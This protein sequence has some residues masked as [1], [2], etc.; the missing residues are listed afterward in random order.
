MGKGLGQAE[1]KAMARPRHDQPV[2]R[3]IHAEIRGLIMRGEFTV[4]SLL[5]SEAKLAAIYRINKCTLRQAL[6]LLRDDGMLRAI[7]SRGWEI[8]ASQPRKA[9]PRQAQ[10]VFMLGPATDSAALAFQ[11]AKRAFVA[12][13]IKADY[14]LHPWDR[15]E[16]SLVSSDIHL[17]EMGAVLVFSD[18][19]L[20][21]AFVSRVLSRGL[22]LV[23]LA[24][25]QQASEY[26]TVAT[27]NAWSG[28]IL[29]DRLGTAGCRRLLYVA[30]PDAEARLPSFRAR[31]QGLAAAAG[32][33]GLAFAEAMLPV[34]SLQ[35]PECEAAFM[36][37]VQRLRAR[38]SMP[39]AMVFA[40]DSL[41]F[42]AVG[43][44]RR[45]GL[46]PERFQFATYGMSRSP[47]LFQAMGYGCPI[48]YVEENWPEI[49]T[50][51][52]EVALARMNGATYAPRLTLVKSFLVDRH[53]PAFP[54]DMAS[55][56]SRPK[57]QAEQERNRP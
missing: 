19:V 29:L 8:L 38:D 36:Q 14:E 28:E 23:D 57:A 53:E 40:V 4:G 7:P 48:P 3:R 27:D 37:V 46:D 18:A 54:A 44:L 50:I 10:A 42:D 39:D 12:A 30:N 52:A 47:E 22:H 11:A 25:Q 35:L 43:V 26:D 51:A 2:Y 1:A 55:P 31:H 17:P 33:R 13:G 32:Q 45:H 34:N 16:Q 5:P 49:G 21:N 9:L 56:P 41:A 15:V 24:L 20:P 6:S